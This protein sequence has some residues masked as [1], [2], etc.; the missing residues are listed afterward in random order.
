MTPQTEVPT[1]HQNPSR[2]QNFR[3]WFAAVVRALDYDPQDHA[4]ARINQ[5]H[6]EVKELQDRLDIA[7][8]QGN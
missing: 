3:T 8:R 7:E 6:Q 4:R 2:W 5:L 1:L